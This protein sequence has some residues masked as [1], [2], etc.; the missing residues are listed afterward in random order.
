M[1]GLDAT[2]KRQLIMSIKLTTVLMITFLLQ[3]AASSNAQNI[4][5]TR[6]NVAI[7]YIFKEIRKQ[8]GYN[9]LWEQD[10]LQT[11]K[12]IDVRFNHTSIDEV[13]KTCLAGQQLTYAIEANTIVIK[14]L[15]VSLI[16]KIISLFKD[17]DIKGRVLDE[18]GLPLP[19]VSILVKGTKTWYKTDENGNFQFK[20][21]D[22]NAVLVFTYLG[23]KSQE[24]PV[25][26]SG[27]I[28]IT[29][30]PVLSDL[31][32]VVVVGYG[33]QKKANLTGAVDAITSKQLEN[34]PVVNLGQGLQGLIPNLNI[35]IANGKPNTAPEF[36]IRGYTSI[37]GGN[38]LILV[39]NVPFSASEL[40][41]LNS[42]DVESV[43]VLK[44]AASAAIYGSRAA[45]GVVLITTKSAKTNKLNVSVN[46]YTAIRTVG[47]LPD[48]VTNPYTALQIKNEA[49]YPLYNPAYSA[50]LVEAARLRSLDPS[51][52]SVIL[53]PNDP[54]KWFYIGTTDWLKEAYNK[55]APTYNAGVTISKKADQVSY[56]L[57]ANYY[58]QNGMAKDAKEKNN[59]YNMRGKVDLNVTKWLTLS[60][61][62]LFSAGT[63]QAPNIVDNDSYFQAINRSNVIDVPRNP[64]GS[65][66]SAGASVLGAAQQGGRKNVDNHTVQ[67][68]FSFDA[69]LIKDVWSL[70][71]DATF[72]RVDTLSRSYSIP[73]PYK[74]GPNL[75]PPLAT[76]SDASNRNINAKYDVVNLY[77][78][79]H[80]RL[81]NHFIS[82]LV[83]YNQEHSINTNF[84]A[85]RKLLISNNIPSVNLATGDQTITENIREWAVQ[86]IFY[87]LNYNFKEKYLVEFNG[88]YDGSSRFG[89][90]KRWA[91]VPS[92]SAGW[93][94][95]EESFFKPVKEAIGMN[96]F[97]IR[98]SYGVLGNQ[99]SVGEY[100]YVALMNSKKGT[101]ILDGKQ[102]T[103]VNPPGAISSDFTWEKVSTIN[104]GADLTFFKN[105]L[106]LNL[107]KYTRYTKN[108][109]VPGK[110]LP[111]VFGTASP[112]TNSADLKTK[113]WEVRLNWRDAVQVGGSPLSYNVTFALSDS[114]AYITR[115]DNPTKSFAFDGKS[116][117][118]GMEIGEIWGL[119][120]E[121]F[122]Q[123]ADE[124]KNHANQ[125]AVGTD[126]QRYQ[127]FVG[128]IKF[129][130]RNGDG[131]VDFGNKTVGN[132]GDLYKIGNSRIHLPYS[133]DLSASWKGFDVRVFLQGVGKRDWYAQGSNIYFWGIY[134]QPWTNVTT[135]NMDHWTPET[136][137]AYFPRVKAYAAEDTG[138]ELGIPNTRYLQNAAY[139]RVKNLT[140]GYTLPKS[141][142]K[143]LK[144]ENVH[145]YVS[146][147]NLFEYSKLKV[148]LDPEGLQGN[149]YP[150]QRTYSFGMNL[151][152]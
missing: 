21:A 105:K 135:Q 94:I 139:L 26:Q 54:N 8:T 24:A 121:G 84:L 57:S 43:S 149:I 64:D 152:F 71:G 82:G 131:K 58:S 120:S 87:R 74:T 53:D 33:T 9:V 23:Y 117:Y 83:G 30:T 17:I 111:G 4:S 15:S 3:A 140:I 12:V 151:N 145:F 73:V 29:L 122:F 62:T 113:G 55:T 116:Y 35:S 106:E 114:R 56:Y 48:V 127:Y 67:T 28:N 81:G 46:S 92:A 129:K 118:E 34:R 128:D 115:F 10:K 32:E 143:K 37:N 88:R 124:L 107:D 38:P 146:G 5:L 70:K 16:T 96:Q 99:A 42:A 72:R 126:D 137:N 27:N 108:M 18:K 75:A 51:L 39:D 142:L 98:G 69:S 45:F 22:A 100:D 130:D 52:P 65:W 89:A 25:S 44:D 66:T 86:G 112:T 36:N 103:Y 134:A 95:S 102:N 97:K 59:L 1:P 63:Y 78:E 14:P 60:N 110:L 136:P 90:G 80:K 49:A 133:I 50:N 119:E 104:M 138:E 7:K 31:T 76:S 91:F 19:S 13:M 11:N 125:T 123:N 101:Q 141:I 148:K 147:E 77:T 41:M 93:V 40:L 2:F 61:N 144:L 132:S 47:K 109:L 85:S 150:F 6:K 68:T 20:V 79:A